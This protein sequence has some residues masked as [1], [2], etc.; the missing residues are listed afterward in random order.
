ME[1][2]VLTENLNIV[3]DI[4][5][6]PYPSALCGL[7]GKRVKNGVSRKEGMAPLKIRIDK[8]SLMN[9]V[10]SVHHKIIHQKLY[11]IISKLRMD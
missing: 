11:R 1:K 7:K 9:T 8:S 10:K 4:P 6:D 3:R 5:L 2:R